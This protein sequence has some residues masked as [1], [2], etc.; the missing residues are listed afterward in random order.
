MTIKISKV[1]QSK[2]NAAPK[3]FSTNNMN[4]IWGKIESQRC[5][6]AYRYL[7]TLVH[8]IRYSKLFIGEIQLDLL[9]P[10]I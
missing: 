10:C 6:D 7:N 2:F 4:N 8:A 9:N 1:E 3:Y 5:F